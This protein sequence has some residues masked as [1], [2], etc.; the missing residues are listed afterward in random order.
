[1]NCGEESRKS[2]FGMTR[3][4]NSAVRQETRRRAFERRRHDQGEGAEEREELDRNAPE[5]TSTV[6]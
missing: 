5:K 4:T 3:A 6:L 2:A 1:M